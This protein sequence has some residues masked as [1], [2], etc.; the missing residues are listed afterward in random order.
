MVSTS[1]QMRRDGYLVLAR[2]QIR[3]YV[4]RSIFY[5]TTEWAFCRNVQGLNVFSFISPVQV[6][7]RQM[8]CVRLVPEGTGALAQP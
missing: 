6:V 1:I 4:Q 8:L 2:H 3:I 5:K 7:A